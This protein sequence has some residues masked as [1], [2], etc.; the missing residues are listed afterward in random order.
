MHH[1]TKLEIIKKALE[2]GLIDQPE[3]LDKPDE[4]MPMWLALEIALK[5]IDRL[6]PPCIGYD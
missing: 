1:H 2:I 3:W 6:D 4:S 5:V